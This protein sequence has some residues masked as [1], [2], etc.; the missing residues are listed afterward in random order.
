MIFSI[1]LDEMLAL[2]YNL[3]KKNSVKG[4]TIWQKSEFRAPNIQDL[5]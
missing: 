3:V 5:K 2:L 1:V 4:D